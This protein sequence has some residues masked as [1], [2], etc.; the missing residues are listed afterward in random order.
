MLCVC[1]T[2]SSSLLDLSED[3][4]L[5]QMYVRVYSYDADIPPAIAAYRA[6]MAR[7]KRKPVLRHMAVADLDTDPDLN[8]PGSK[9]KVHEFT[10][11][12]WTEGISAGVMLKPEEARFEPD[13]DAIKRRAL[14]E[15]FL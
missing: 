7:E 10:W 15:P 9:L 12:K 1:C 13:F 6:R 4:Q 8:R 11:Q 2:Y 3:A 5:I 14:W